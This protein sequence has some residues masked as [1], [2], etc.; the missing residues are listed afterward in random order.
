MSVAKP[1]MLGSPEPLTSHS[2]AGL[3]GF[4]FSQTISFSIGTS[5]GAAWAGRASTA[6]ARTSTEATKTARRLSPGNELSQGNDPP[7]RRLW[8]R[9]TDQRSPK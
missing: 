5:H 9:T 2:L 8:V 1:W 6:K 7:A 4:E 3:P